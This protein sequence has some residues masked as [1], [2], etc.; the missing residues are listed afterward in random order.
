MRV[1]TG[2]A[3]GG[4]GGSGGVATGPLD[5]LSIVTSVAASLWVVGDL[6]VTIATGVSQWDDQSAGASSFANATTGQQPT[7]AAS[8]NGRN[9]VTF[10]GVDDTLLNGT[11]NLP[12]PGTINCWIFGIIKVNAWVL[13]KNVWGTSATGYA[14]R[15]TTSTPNLA[16]FNTTQGPDNG[17]AAVG[18]WV[19]AQQF[20]T[21]SVADY[22]TLG[23]TKVTGV[24]MGNNNP[25][26][27]FRIGA[28]SAST[29]SLSCSI[30]CLGIWYAEPTTGEKNALDAWST[31]Y[32]GGGVQI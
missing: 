10:D 15:T 11:L 22:L 19:R 21:N 26:A 5:P 20:F 8:L 3:L 29:T 28:G 30:A 12:A 31:S 4:G 25:A 16:G 17:G 6:G 9:V 1:G 24:N 23:A 13:N 18:S 14:L 2:A 32:Y 27:S 7:I